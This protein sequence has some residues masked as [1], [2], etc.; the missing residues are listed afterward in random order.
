MNDPDLVIAETGGISGIV[1]E[2]EKVPRFPIVAV[3]SATMGAD[4]QGTAA[5]LQQG[6]DPVVGQ[7]A[8]IVHIVEKVVEAIDLSSLIH[9]YLNRWNN[10][11]QGLRF[12]CN[13]AN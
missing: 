7:R 13:F 10:R 4:P 3:Q 6:P 12:D 9:K 11:Y 2:M 1:G 5:V 8:R